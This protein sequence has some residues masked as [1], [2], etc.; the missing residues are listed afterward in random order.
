[1]S[2]VV[3]QAAPLLKAAGFRKRRH[4][5]NRTTEPGLVQVVNFWMGPFDPPGPGSEKHQAA[6]K[7]LGLRGDYYG[8]FTI[9]LGVYV[10][11]M[12]LAESDRPG[13]WVNE[14]D[15]QLRKAI[16]E[17]LPDGKDVWWSL[18]RSDVAAD[19]VLDA[20]QEACLPWLDRL[21][22][23][24]AILAA[25]EVVGWLGLGMDGPEG[26]AWL[27]KDR[28]RVRAKAVLRAYLNNDLDPGDREQAEAW[29]RQH[30]F[31]QLLD[32]ETP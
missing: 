21:A 15:C 11:E 4:N 8:T 9:R 19:V 25:Y 24:D 27:L 13:A 10:P 30:G 3:A 16:G 5:F 7:A 26:V 6:R 29:L 18:D 14:Y 28:D 20:L 2:K 32:E 17:L 23:R 1:M 22:S 12:V 31:A